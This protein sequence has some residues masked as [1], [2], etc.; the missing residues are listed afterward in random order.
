LE[1]RFLPPSTA[2][3]SFSIICSPDPDETEWVAPEASPN[4]SPIARK[5]GCPKSSRLF[6]KLL[7][8]I[9]G[10]EEMIWQGRS[11]KNLQRLMP[12]MQVE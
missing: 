10:S 8:V 2:V 7:L 12:T 9:L 3:H 6:Q 5:V 4:R 11:L 1:L